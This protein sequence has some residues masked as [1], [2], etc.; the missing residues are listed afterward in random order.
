MSKKF[1]PILLALAAILCTLPLRG[2]SPP[3]YKKEIPVKKIENS[4]LIKSLNEITAHYLCAVNSIHTTVA[5]DMGMIEMTVTNL[6]TGESWWDTFDSGEAPQ[7][8][9]P[10][11]GDPGYYKVEYITESGDIYTGEF[12]IE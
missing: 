10:I 9:L 3:E 2:D 7:S 11:S 8:I 5:S 6:S 1:I 4:Y 12:L